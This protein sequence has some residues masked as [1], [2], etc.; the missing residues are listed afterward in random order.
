MQ[1]KQSALRVKQGGGNVR[2][3]GNT[4]ARRL[5]RKWLA[6]ESGYEEETWPLLKQA[7]QEN[8]SFLQ[9]KLFRDG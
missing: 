6:D 7:L 4:A 1:K 9:R 3:Q 5:L 8:R 2:L